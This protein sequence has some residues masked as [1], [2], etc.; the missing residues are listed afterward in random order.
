M[1]NISIP[2]I[3]EALSGGGEYYQEATIKRFLETTFLDE[4]ILTS[5]T[6]NTLNLL[7]VVIGFDIFICTQ[8]KDKE[9]RK[10]FISLSIILIV[11]WII[12]AFGLLIT[13]LFIL[14]SS[15]AMMLTCYDRYILTIP[16][17]IIFI[18]ILF[19]IKINKNNRLKLSSMAIIFTILLAFMPMK[20]IKNTYIEK[21]KNIEGTKAYREEFRGILNYLD[22]M[23]LDDK[24]YYISNFENEREIAIVTYEFLPLKIANRNQRLIMRK[25]DFLDIL[26]N[27]GYTHIYINT[28]DREL[29]KQYIDLFEEGEVQDKTM[30]EIVKLNGKISFKKV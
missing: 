9:L 28:I 18:N 2:K 27:E 13:Y 11:S 12:Y 22:K 20:G 5:R 1:N 8:I 29:K 10:R 15:E 14:T 4:G 3:L 17:G 7:M 16:L 23:D 26:M 21:E 19:I 30:Y 25:E 6:M 24:I